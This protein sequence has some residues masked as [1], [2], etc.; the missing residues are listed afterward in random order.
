MAMVSKTMSSGGSDDHQGK[1]EVL[2][3]DR[4]KQRAGHITDLRKKKNLPKLGV[5]A[6]PGEIQ[7]RGGDVEGGGKANKR[8][9]PK[10]EFSK[11]FKDDD[12]QDQGIPPGSDHLIRA[13]RVFDRDADFLPVGRKV[14]GDEYVATHSEFRQERNRYRDHGNQMSNTGETVSIRTGEYLTYT[15]KGT[16]A[17]PGEEKERAD[18]ERKTPAPLRTIMVRLMP[19]EATVANPHLSESALDRAID[20]TARAFAKAMGQADERYG[21]GCE[22]VSAAV[23]RMENHD[24]HLHLQYSMV[25]GAPETPSMLG[26]RLKPWRIGA[27]KM[28]CEELAAKGIT[29]PGN[30]A[31]GKMKQKLIAD[32]KL[33][34]APVAQIE[35]RK[36]SG[37]RSLNE[38]HILGHSFRFKMNLV[39]VA[40][41]AGRQDIADLVTEK[42]DGQKGFRAVAH[43]TEAQRVEKAEFFGLAE[44]NEE[45][46]YI[47]LWLERVWRNAIKDQLPDEVL[48]EMEVAGVQAAKDY[49]SYGTVMIESTVT[50]RANHGKSGALDFAIISG[51]S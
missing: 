40:E 1:E 37:K 31:I 5:D 49:A 26:R 39:R 17:A 4:E 8:D 21:L 30:R 28:A 9:D 44:Y 22:V 2:V 10:E 15:T 20:E 18:K 46:A 14:N 19:H 36:F 41:E 24:L 42:R 47:D 13:R 29:N 45:D 25:V 11:A 7:T 32:E 12:D 6:L 33:D 34:P 23:H 43:P 16:D 27:T 50:L 3:K 48:K 35:Y 51:L 38:K